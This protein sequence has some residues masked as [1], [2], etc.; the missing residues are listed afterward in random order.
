M[1][2]NRPFR[3]PSAGAPE[4]SDLIRSE[5]RRPRDIAVV[6]LAGAAAWVAVVWLWTGS[7]SGMGSAMGLT[8]IGFLGAWT[9]MM[10]AMMLPAVAPVASLYAASFRAFR[11]RR[12]AEFTA[13]YLLVWAALGV[14]AFGVARAADAISMSNPE[15]LRWAVVAILLGLAG[16][17][18]TG[19][20]RM[21]LEH[22]R[23]PLS[24]LLHYAGYT[25]A[26]RDLRAGMHHALYCAGCCWPLMLLLIAVGTMNLAAML[27]LSAVVAGEKLL[28]FGHAISRVAAAAAVIVAAVFV[29]SPALFGQVTG[30]S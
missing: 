6:A 27:V 2:G 4:E 25:G 10:A 9:L 30:I 14:P 3:R 1:R 5:T 20:K 16:Y 11:G 24:L 17:Q 23:S 8:V 29:L 18:L 26:T 28:P 7:S 21:C 22:C 19:L 13:G 12:L 15:F